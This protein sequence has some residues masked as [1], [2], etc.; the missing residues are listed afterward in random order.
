MLIAEQTPDPD[1]E[2]EIVVFEPR[3]RESCARILATL[4]E[5]FGASS[6]EY[7]GDLARFPTFLAQR[8]ESIAGFVTLRQ[9]YAEA[10]EIH[11]LA[12]ERAS[13]RRGVGRR[14]VR[15]AEEW[16]RSKGVQV[17]HVKT[18]GPSHPDPCY[19]RTRDFYRALG[20]R[21]V[22]ETTAIWGPD[23]PS[24]VLVKLLSP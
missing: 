13:H 17:L 11:C 18:V 21:R 2:L 12:I 9:H 6:E 1:S 5:W 19:A 7:I 4:P 20:F 10:W 8:R 16:L 3:M 14:L 24:L 22:F 23:N 15:H